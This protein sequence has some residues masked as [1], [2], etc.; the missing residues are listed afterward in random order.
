MLATGTGFVPKRR[1]EPVEFVSS[2]NSRSGCVETVM[3][4]RSNVFRLVLPS[5]LE[6]VPFSVISASLC[7][8]FFKSHKKYW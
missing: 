5:H 7:I 2:L 1:H 4:V 3:R 6:R 8:F